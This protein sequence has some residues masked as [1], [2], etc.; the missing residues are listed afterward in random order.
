[1]N[2]SSPRRR[3]LSVTAPLP[4]LLLGVLVMR[5]AGVSPAIWGQNLAIGSV[6]AV[7]CALLP[8]APVS[9]SKPWWWRSVVPAVLGLL[10]ATFLDAGSEG[11]YRWVP[12]GPL[13]L[14]AAA[15]ALPILVIVLGVMSHKAGDKYQGWLVLLAGSAALILLV[16]QP[17]AAQVTAFA[18]AL[19]T[20]LIFNRMPP[21]VTILAVLVTVAAVIWAW[22]R[23][24]PLQPVPHVE[25]IVGLAG[26]N[27]VLWRAGAL[28]ALALLPLPFLFATR[29][30]SPT[31]FALGIYFSL[32]EV[33]S[34]LGAFPVPVMGF[35]LSPILGY[36]V[37]L[38]WLTVCE[39]QADN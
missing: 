22:R 6:L 9:R 25:G 29:N 21:S 34:F 4:A 12:V 30:S 8:T 11:V 2:A 10:A 18:S 38:G 13:R 26:Q 37:A 39:H 32:C 20:L 28:L 27:G 31:P 36:F 24:D 15:I 33:G 17:D 35:G 16:A 3:G 19:L 23:A 14:H 1:M 5:R 7:V